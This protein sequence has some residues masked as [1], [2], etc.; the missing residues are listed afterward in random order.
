MTCAMLSRSR[1]PE[2][3]GARYAWDAVGGSAL[4]GHVLRTMEVGASS[5]RL[6]AYSLSNAVL[7]N[8]VVATIPF[9]SR[10]ER[11]RTPADAE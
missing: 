1:G 2:L 8:G 4:R 10:P 6:L 11:L 7:S 9:T 3:R 5:Q